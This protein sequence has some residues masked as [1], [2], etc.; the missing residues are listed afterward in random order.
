MNLYKKEY[1]IVQKQKNAG[2]IPALVW[3]LPFLL[4]LSASANA[5]SY[6]ET[7][8]QNRRQFRKFQWKYFDTRHFRVYHYDKAG[9]QLGRYAAEEA[10]NDIAVVEK[11]LG[12]RFPKK[13]NIVL[14]NS[15]EEYRQTN[16]GLKQETGAPEN[17]RAGTLNL[18]DDKLVVYFTGQHADLRHQILSGMSRVV[19]EK[20]VF[21]ENFKKMVKNALLLN[22]PAWVT[23]GYIAFLVDGWDTKS[24]SE[25]KSLLDARPKA[26]FYEL[27]EEHPELA[28]KAFWKFVSER[29]S[30]ATVKNLLYSMQNHT[31]LNKS[32]KAPGNLNMNV[33]KAYDSCMSFYKDVFAK[34][35][36]LQE[37][38][39]SSRGLLAIKLPAGNAT[40]RHITVSPRGSDVTYVAWQNGE[41]TVYTQKTSGT[42][43]KTVLLEGGEKDLTEQTDPDYPLLAYSNTGNKLAL[44][45]KKGN[46]TRLRIYNSQKG[47]V[48]NYVIQK[49]RFD[50][51][52][53]MTFMEDDNKM[54][55][56]AIKK[57]QTDLYSVTL[58]GFKMENITDDVWDDV[59]PVFVSGGSRKGILF[60]SNRPKPN[61]DVPLSVNE[62]PTGAMNVFFYNTTTKRRELLQ[63]SHATTGHITQPIQYGYD[64]FAYLL[65]ANGI[66][67]K[68]VVMFARTA[69]NM[70]SAYSVPVTNYT[71]SLLSH[72]Y[73][74]AANEA[75]DVLQVKDHYEAFFHPLVMPGKDV[76]PKVLTLTT[77]S[78]VKPEEEQSPQ[79]KAF[80]HINRFNEQ[81]EN[82][83]PEIKG[84]N[85]FQ[86]EFTD[87][88]APQKPRG[89][90]RDRGRDKDGDAQT[91][92]KGNADSSML[93]V[94]TDSSYLNMKPS[95]YRLSF[96]PDFFSV[97]LDNS[98]LFSQYQS[99][100]KNGGQYVNPSLGTLTTLSL[101]EL[102]EDHRFTGGF[103]LPLNL[104]S[105]A[106]F[107]QYQNYKHMIDWSLM[108][109]HEQSK[110]SKTIAFVDPAGNVVGYQDYTFKS[111]MDMLQADLSYPISRVRAIKFH[112][113]LRE[114]KMTPKATDT[115]SLKYLDGIF[116][117]QYWSMSRLEFIFDNTIS[118]V[119]NI[120]FGTRYKAYA[121]YMYELNMGA[122]SCY[123]IGFDFRTYQKIYKNI[124]WAT[125]AAYAHSDGT[126]E[127]AYQMGGVDNWISAK[128]ASS[129]SAEGN[130]GFIAMTTNLR[131]YY[132]NARSGNNFAVLNT[133][134]RMPVLTTFIHRP[135][136]SAILKNLQFITFADAGSAWNGF[137][138]TADATATKYY[139]PTLSS[140]PSPT[141]NIFVNV[142]IPNGDGLALGYGCGLRTTLLGYF[143]RLDA[144]W[145]IDDS[146]KKPIYYFSLG[147]DF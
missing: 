20:M 16:I 91:A 65:D 10:E 146:P 34:D 127:V 98:V 143:I 114:E 22:L 144:A 141:N 30:L 37:P 120:R 7:F 52:L 108:F 145:S 125:R 51:V 142:T 23:E 27:S 135:I 110:D 139:Y 68:F 44:M 89:H 99:F 14:Y 24:S 31:S 93:T 101:N 38:P 87:T 59:A 121:E 107:L 129:G 80:D 133:E 115:I 12:G 48:E 140:N 36:L 46:Q 66:T 26:G 2:I 85:E 58:K 49:N 41:Y 63:C 17:T 35:A 81:P 25:W 104:S 21:G 3:L 128:Q 40:I 74:L 132:Q 122:Q 5:Q 54:V 33:T 130:P 32:M 134:I 79:K 39:D 69:Q 124:I 64:N 118:P 6:T 50:R 67:N 43:E 111:S 131:G 92:G 71:T 1:H 116:P 53:G 90:N 97:R 72:Q 57:S 77:L 94:I 8:G 113:S 137:L 100:G 88:A 13:F 109:M 105:S 112:T 73:N 86:T 45:Y 126:S 28:G 119:E 96:K 123:N 82:S 61:M 56:S 136:Q 11:K 60:L 70:D 9:R 138:P 18:V 19:M 147:T 42:Q 47:K 75:A 106:Y 55:I 76:K 4:L 103:Q 84:G 83:L 117:T 62:M 15:Y 29:Y 95:T 102:M 78:V